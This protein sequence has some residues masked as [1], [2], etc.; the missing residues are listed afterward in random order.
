[1]NVDLIKKRIGYLVSGVPALSALIAI[2]APANVEH[3]RAA[4]YLS[5]MRHIVPECIILASL[6]LLLLLPKPLSF[7]ADAGAS[8]WRSVFRSP[9]FGAVYGRLFSI[10]PWIVVLIAI[11]ASYPHAKTYARARYAYLFKDGLQRQFQTEQLTQAFQYEAGYEYERA[12]RKYTDIGEMF[13]HSKNAALLAERLSLDRGLV[14]YAERMYALGKEEEGRHGVSRLALNFY[15]ESLRTNPRH[16]ES[17]R[18]LLA[19]KSDLETRIAKA[20]PMFQDCSSKQSGLAS[21]QHPSEALFFLMDLPAQGATGEHQA[22]DVCAVVLRFPDQNAFSDAVKKSWQLDRLDAL[23]VYSQAVQR[24]KTMSDLLGKDDTNAIPV[25][26][27]ATALPGL[28]DV[29][30]VEDAP[31]PEQQGAATTAVPSM[32]PLPLPPPPPSQR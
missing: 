16:A 32:P 18:H 9:P 20:V 21:G 31:A 6:G 5:L 29:E 23:M 3:A 28:A 14:E 30:D 27:T 15:L 26:H 17:Q 24:G 8:S 7:Y 10:A 25:Y 13:P 1:M 19:F 12:I 11:G 22:A 2:I 4:F